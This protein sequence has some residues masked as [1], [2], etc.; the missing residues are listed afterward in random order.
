MTN[1]TYYQRLGGPMLTDHRGI[2]RLGSGSFVEAFDASTN[3][4]TKIPSS[5]LLDRLEDG[6]LDIEPISEERVLELTGTTREH[7]LVH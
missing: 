1:W 2:L 5:V 4:W 3:S 6:A 7:H